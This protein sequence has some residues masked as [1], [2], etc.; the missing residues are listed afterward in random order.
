[1]IHLF[2]ACLLWTLLLLPATDAFVHCSAPVDLVARCGDLSFDL[3]NMRNGTSTTFVGTDTFTES[4]IYM[5]L[6]LPGLDPAAVAHQTGLSCHSSV[7][8][9]GVL[10]IQPDNSGCFSLGSLNSMAWKYLPEATTLYVSVFNGDA[11]LNSFI[12]IKCGS[13]PTTFTVFG[14]VSSTLYIEMT[15]PA[16]CGSFNPS[17]MTTT[18]V[19]TTSEIQIASQHWLSHCSNLGLPFS[20]SEGA[21]SLAAARSVLLDITENERRVI[22]HSTWEGTACSG[23]PIFEARFELQ[24]N[25]DS[26]A[27]SESAVLQAVTIRFGD[28]LSSLMD[29]LNKYCPCSKGNWTTSTWRRVGASMCNDLPAVN[30]PWFCW[31]LGGNPVT[32]NTVRNGNAY[33]R[34]LLNSSVIYP[35]APADSPFLFKLSLDEFPD[36]SACSYQAWSYCGTY[37]DDAVNKCAAIYPSHMEFREACLL[38][39]LYNPTKDFDMN[40]CCPC[41]EKYADSYAPWAKLPCVT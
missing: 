37:I 16:G 4:L 23:N 12:S 28:K 38:A 15:S 33:T 36:K 13:G 25:S 35:N 30:A 14:A 39:G 24:S 20:V 8:A 21:P 29:S 5:D 1:M 9:I 7:R 31:L 22:F 26:S 19:A 10:Q 40:I 32:I 6:A 17:P 27:T 18:P 41:L 3:L 11:G 34:T 2:T